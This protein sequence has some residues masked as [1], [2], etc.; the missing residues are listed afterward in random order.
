V[1]HE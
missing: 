1:I